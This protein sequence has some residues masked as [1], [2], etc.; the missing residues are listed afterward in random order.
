MKNYMADQKVPDLH[1]IQLI[2]KLIRG[3]PHVRSEMDKEIVRNIRCIK[4][5]HHPKDNIWFGIIK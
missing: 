2:V 4:Y 5:L 1:K 3:V